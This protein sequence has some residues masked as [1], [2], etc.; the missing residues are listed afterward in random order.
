MGRVLLLNAS[1]EPLQLITPRRA[2]LLVLLERA[3]V[4]ARHDDAPRFRAPSAE[5]VV[6]SVVRLRHYVK[7]PFRAHQPPLSRRAVLARDHHRCAYCGNHA[8]TV[9]HVV[10][11]SRGGQH[12]WTNVVAACK[13]HNLQKGNRLLAELGWELRREPTA[14]SGLLW[15]WRHLDEVDPLWSDYLGEHDRA[16]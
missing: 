13:R 4:V 5:V 15:R 1:F 7:V 16:A 14:P 8:D 10:P 2:V 6:P 9:D 3:E 12:V 11:R